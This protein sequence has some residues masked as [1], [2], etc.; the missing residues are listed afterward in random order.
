MNISAPFIVRPIATTLLMAGLTLVGLVAY[1]ILPIA[2]VPQVD[3]P[4][5][6]IRTEFPGAS[7]ETMATSVAA[8]LERHL[9]LI[10]GVTSMSS[11]SSLGSTAIQ[12]EFELAASMRRRRMSKPR[13]TRRVGS[14]R[15]ACPTRRPTRRSIPPMRC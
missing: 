10:S 5:I 14:F 7:A 8:P 2:G 11:S 3:I 12:V 9:A 4:T 15:K 1:F 13:S 6:Q